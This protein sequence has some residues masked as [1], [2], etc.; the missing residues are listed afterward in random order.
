MVFNYSGRNQVPGMPATELLTQ[1]SQIWW[2]R[3]EPIVYAGKLL[4]KDTVDSG[5]TGNTSILREGLALGLITA[6]DQLTHW[7]PYATDGS[8]KFVG[9]LAIPQE[10]DYN[11][12]AT[13]RLTAVFVAGQIKASQVVVPG[14]TSK[15][16]AGTDYEFLLREQCAGRFLFDDDLGSLAAWKTRELPATA[17]LTTADHKTHFTNVGAS[18]AT[19]ITLPVPVPGLHFRFSS[20]AAHNITLEGPA[21]GEYFPAANS[22]VLSAANDETVDVYAIRTAATPTYQY[23][24]VPTP[25]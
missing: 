23:K 3:H 14:E 19:T 22:D 10:M 24:I 11:G 7:N 12:T 4:D 6:S 8:G 18:G 15:G 13:E 21:T 5:N 16:L 25:A 1:E 9:F 2:G 20:I 17:T